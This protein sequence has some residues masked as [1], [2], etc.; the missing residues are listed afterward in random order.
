MPYHLPKTR[1]AMTRDDEGRV[2]HT[3]R[4]SIPAHPVRQL[5][6]RWYALG[7]MMIAGGL[8]TAGAGL[9]GLAGA[10]A[11]LGAFFLWTA[12]ANDNRGDAVQ[13]A[14]TAFERLTRGRVDECEALLARIPTRAGGHVARA[15][16]LQRAMIAVHRGDAAAALAQASRACEGRPGLLSRPHDVRQMASALSLRAIAHASLGDATAAR[17]DADA[18]EASEGVSPPVLARSTLARAIVLA[19]AAD[20]DGL[21]RHFA[22]AGARQMEWLT[23]RERILFRALR[24]M[25]RARP[26]SVYRESARPDERDA[27]DERA[28]I[29][30]LVPGASTFAPPARHLEAVDPAPA[31]NASDEG[32]RQV[33]R[34]RV[35]ARKPAPRAKLRMLTLWGALVVTFLA[36]WQ[37]LAPSDGPRSASA[38]GATPDWGWTLTVGPIASTIVFVVALITWQN[39]RSGRALRRMQ[40]AELAVARGDDQ[41]AAVLLDEVARSG[42][43][44]VAATARA[45]LARTS[46][47]QARWDDAIAQCDEGIARATRRAPTR[48]YVSDLILPELVELRAVAL[49]ALD[50]RAESDAELAML[51]RDFPTYAFAARA[52][53]RAKLVGAARAGDMAGAAQIARGRTLDLPLPLRE[54]V[55]GDVALAL[56]SGAAREELG[57]LDGELRE[58]GELRAWLDAI[59]PELRGRLRARAGGAEAARIG[60]VRVGGGGDAETARDAEAVDEREPAARPRATL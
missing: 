6:T 45:H 21:A 24:G 43:D 42:V 57:R 16:A 48:A 25:A 52:V 18:A 13:L 37:I 17:A 30:K 4:S 26:K 7:A 56:A 39:A 29:D 31:T 53:L 5:T 58:D 23:P 40:M 34:A 27:E 41:G 28:W 10:C 54:D 46:V 33:L 11:V 3:S 47:R 55:L 60:G 51:A 38:S 9:F 12:R 14:N 8:V 2:S 15:V 59:D 20:T 49:A 22:A 35:A 1:G 50:R 32:V 44:A 19:A 36:I